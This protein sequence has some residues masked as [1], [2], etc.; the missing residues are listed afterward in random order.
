V[1]AV[2]QRWLCLLQLGRDLIHL[3]Y[4]RAF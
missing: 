1:H 2:T 3:E 4:A